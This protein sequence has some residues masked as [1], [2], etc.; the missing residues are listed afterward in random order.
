MQLYTL[1]NNFI[2]IR[3]LDIGASIYTFEIKPKNYRNI[4]LSLAN[5][6]DYKTAASGYFGATIGRVAGRIDKG[7]FKIKNKTY[8]TQLNE[9]NTNSLHGGHESFAFKKFR[10]IKLTLTELVFEYVSVD[11]EGGYPAE[12]KLHVIY[13]LRDVGLEINYKATT[14]MDTILNITNHSYFNLDGDGTILNHILKA[15]ATH[16]YTHDKKQLNDELIVNTSD[17]PFYIKEG[18]KLQD[19]IL[20]PLVNKEP[21]MGFDHL[22]LIDGLLTFKTKDITLE[23]ISN[24][25]AVQMYST[26]FPSNLLLVGHKLVNLY[27]ALAIEPVDIVRSQ[28]QTFNN[29]LVTKSKPYERTIRYIIKISD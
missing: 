22:L 6:N 28:N 13:T 12:V 18:K 14:T 10:L 19:I 29:L 27:H 7:V 1:E 15:N 26:N 9:K 3:F 16:Y 21:A 23:V 2:R 4:V 5:L 25:P 11:G 17:S 24:Y 20:H 8:Q